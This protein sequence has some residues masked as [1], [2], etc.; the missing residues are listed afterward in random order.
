M[1][2]KTLSILWYANDSTI[3]PKSEGKLN[4]LWI[5]ENS[6]KIQYGLQY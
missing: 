3:F 5:Y 1:N 6:R 4:S 2:Y